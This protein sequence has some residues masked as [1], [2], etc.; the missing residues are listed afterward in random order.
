MT[1]RVVSIKKR[2]PLKSE[3]DLQE[4]KEAL[5]RAGYTEEEALEIIELSN[6]ETSVTSRRVHKIG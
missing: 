4:Y 3:L 2:R 1:K 6:K 5:I